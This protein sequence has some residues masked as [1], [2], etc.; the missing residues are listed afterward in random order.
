L[1]ANGTFSGSLPADIPRGAVK[2]DI[3]GDDYTGTIVQAEND[4]AISEIEQDH[5]HDTGAGGRKR[6]APGAAAAP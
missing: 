4:E 2:G 3:P 6:F 1:T 5:H